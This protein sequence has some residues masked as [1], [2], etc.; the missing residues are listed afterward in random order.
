MDFDLSENTK[1]K[2]NREELLKKVATGSTDW[3]KELMYESPIKMIQT[4]M[5]SQ[6]ETDCVS[7]VQS[8]GFDV[9]A[10]ELKKALAYDRDQYSKGFKDARTVPVVIHNVVFGNACG[11]SYPVDVHGYLD[12]SR[13]II[14][15]EPNYSTEYAE[16]QGWVIEEIKEPF[17]GT[18]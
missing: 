1:K 11:C 15:F 12:K 13:N 18:L 10:E 4:Q 3:E 2:F 16:Q 7:V 6:M 14:F 9:D 17:G 5:Q 8:Y